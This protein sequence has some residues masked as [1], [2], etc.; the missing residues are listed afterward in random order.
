[1]FFK[2]VNL[3]NFAISTGNTHEKS[4]FKK[5]IGKRPQHRFFPVSIAKVLRT[6]SFIEQLR[7]L[8]GVL[9]QYN[10]VS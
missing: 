2:I 1:M 3:K 5:V 8:L 6:A 4:I 7:L 9:P 10:K